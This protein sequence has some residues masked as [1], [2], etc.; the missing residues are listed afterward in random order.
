MCGPTAQGRIPFDEFATRHL[1]I[2]DGAGHADAFLTL[3]SAAMTC[4]S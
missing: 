2:V 4:S 1:E 3:M